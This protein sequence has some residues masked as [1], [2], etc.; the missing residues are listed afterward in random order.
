[1]DFLQLHKPHS[2]YPWWTVFM[3]GT[4]IQKICIC[5]GLLK[6]SFRRQNTESA[7]AN[8]EKSLPQCI[9]CSLVQLLNLFIHANTVHIFKDTVCKVE[10]KWTVKYTADVNV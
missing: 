10:W 9:H 2:R 5:A 1:M 6:V 3:P 7:L 4:C 8:H